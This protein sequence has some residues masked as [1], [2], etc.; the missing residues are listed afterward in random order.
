M[1]PRLEDGEFHRRK[2]WAALPPAQEC[3]KDTWAKIERL[4]CIDTIQIDLTS[5][6]TTTPGYSFDR[7]MYGRDVN[8]AQPTIIFDSKSKVYR[9]NARRILNDAAIEVDAR[10]I[11]LQF[12]KRGPVLSASQE[13][14]DSLAKEPECSSSK[15]ISQ[16]ATGASITIESTT[17]TMGGLISINGKLFGLTVGHAFNG[18]NLGKGIFHLNS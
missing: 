14:G 7:F 9:R 13:T 12:Y 18:I 2:C 11:G 4:F 1:E 6:E 3:L 5:G 16:Y 10:G 17:C 15:N 8:D